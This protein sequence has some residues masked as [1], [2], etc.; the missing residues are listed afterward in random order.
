MICSACGSPN[1]EARL[2]EKQKFDLEMSINLHKNKVNPYVNLYSQE[3]E[4]QNNFS[5]LIKQEKEKI[6]PY[7]LQIISTESKI[8]SLFGECEDYQVSINKVKTYLNNLSQLQDILIQTRGLFFNLN[9][10]Q[11]QQDTNKFLDTYFDSIIKV[12]LFVEKDDS[13]EVLIHKDSYQCDY[14]QLSK[15]Q[16]GILKLCFATSVMLMAANNA[17]IHFNLLMFD[18]SLDGLD[19]EMKIKAHSF[20][21]HVSSNRSSTLVVDHSLE[22]KSV[23]TEALTVI[24]TGGYSTII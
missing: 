6:N 4:K 8:K 20:F 21:Q 22:L 2:L 10:K 7:N 16:K 13:I 9:I 23:F 11:I 12:E 14:S 19:G 24:N 1:K 5:E 15:G 3:Q 17:G 18:E